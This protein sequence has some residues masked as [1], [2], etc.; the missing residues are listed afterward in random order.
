V[1]ADEFIV[2]VLIL[3]CAAVVAM[4]AMHSRRQQPALGAD[5]PAV[6]AEA[7]NVEEQGVAPRRRRPR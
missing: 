5:V 4:L 2:L 6:P 1:A 3:A 7:D